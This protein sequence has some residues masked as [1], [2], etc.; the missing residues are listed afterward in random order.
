MKI[1]IT[2]VTIDGIRVWQWRIMQG[3]KIAFGGLCRT[4]R[5]AL[6]DAGIVLRENQ[7]TN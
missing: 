7:T 4:K 1:K 2:R 6:N 5:D 3:R